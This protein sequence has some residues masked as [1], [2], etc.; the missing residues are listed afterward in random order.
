[1]LRLESSCLVSAHT[2]RRFGFLEGFFLLSSS[3]LWLPL[4][5][6]FLSHSWSRMR[7]CPDFSKAGPDSSLLSL[8][9]N[10]KTTRMR[11]THVSW[12]SAQF[13]Q[14]LRLQ[15]C[16]N[17][18]TGVQS[19]CLLQVIID[20]PFCKVVPCCMCPYLITHINHQLR[21]ECHGNIVVLFIY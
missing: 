13:P 17:E 8:G 21:I 11:W 1:M 20:F 2:T 10:A 7:A 4:F 16:T 14:R 9:F 12:I 6:F 19:H 3:R 5:R 18:L 15:I